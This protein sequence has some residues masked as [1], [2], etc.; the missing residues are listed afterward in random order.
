MGSL[1]RRERGCHHSQYSNACNLDVSF[2]NI[3][4]ADKVT[5][6]LRFQSEAKIFVRNQGWKRLLFI[7]STLTLYF[8]KNTGAPIVGIARWCVPRIGQGHLEVKW[9]TNGA[10]S[11]VVCQY[12]IH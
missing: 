2:L 10:V 11:S 4:N 8:E 7:R 5:N 12:N 1:S 3:F 9:S 6:L